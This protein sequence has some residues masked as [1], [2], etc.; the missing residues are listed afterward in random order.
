MN[1]VE[2]LAFS[3]RCAQLAGSFLLS[4]LPMYRTGHSRK[5]RVCSDGL[6]K[7]DSLHRT[8]YEGMGRFLGNY[9]VR[10]KTHV[11]RQEM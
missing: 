5:E 8:K 3:S 4:P 10:G 7:E 11:W 9:R 6:L 2:L 1:N